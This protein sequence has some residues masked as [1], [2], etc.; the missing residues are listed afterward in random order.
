[1][2]DLFA[3]SVVFT[4]TDGEIE[5]D[6]YDFV[7]SIWKQIDFM[8]FKYD[9][10]ID[11]EETIQALPDGEYYSYIE[12]KTMFESDIDW[13][14]GREEGHFIFEIETILTQRIPR[15]SIR[16]RERNYTLYDL[17]VS[18]SGIIFDTESHNKSVKVSTILENGTYTALVRFGNSVELISGNT[19]EDVLETISKFSGQSTR[20]EWLFPVK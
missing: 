20:I 11:E 14:S 10:L 17:A 5:I 13:E 18:Y 3:C 8:D 19:R 15:L 2:G 9:I 4:K 6:E 1:M 7:S 12:G 16:D